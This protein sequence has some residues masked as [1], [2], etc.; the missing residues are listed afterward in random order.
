MPGCSDQS[1]RDAIQRSYRFFNCTV[2]PEPSG[3]MLGGFNFSHRT[4][5][6][7]YMEQ[8][9]GARRRARDIPEVALWTTSSELASMDELQAD[10]DEG[11]RRF[12]E[13]VGRAP[14]GAST[15]LAR[16]L[17][18]LASDVYHYQADHGTMIWPAENGATDELFDDEMYALRRNGYYVVTYVGHPIDNTFYTDK[19]VDWIRRDSP[20][21]DGCP[22]LHSANYEDTGVD[23]PAFH[24]RF[25]G[26]DYPGFDLT[27]PFL[28]GGLTMV[29]TP[30][31]G[32]GI[33]A[34]NWS[35]ITH[36]GVVGLGTDPNSGALERSWER[37]AAT[38]FH[39]ADRDG[40]EI[41]GAI[42]MYYESPDE[43]TYL[44][45]YEFEDNEITVEITVT[46]E[47]DVPQHFDALWENIPVP[48]CDSDCENNRK[49]RLIGFADDG[50]AAL[51]EGDHL[52]DAVH[53]VDEEGHGL[54]VELIDGE[55]SVGVRPVGMTQV[56]YGTRLHIGRLEIPF[57][58]AALAPGES[59]TLRYRIRTLD[60]IDEPP[61]SPEADDIP[62]IIC[63]AGADGDADADAD[64]DGD[65]DG[66]GDG[67]SD[68]DADGDGDADGD[69]DAD[70]DGDGDADGGV[71]P[72][73]EG[74]CDCRAGARRSSGFLLKLI[75]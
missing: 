29:W 57:D 60:P 24:T 62:E 61:P 74:G 64:G 32:A 5:W 72:S 51:S 30:D 3:G 22:L 47:T 59:T 55:R 28:G 1:V 10:V 46:N 16:F 70:G 2:G 75:G 56:Q 11:I 9:G 53:I 41:A 45:Q 37:I 68:V 73:D 42:P 35:P 21:T 34:T 26:D 39:H 6:G 65:S 36:H 38:D 8:Y 20:P 54:A 15:V 33:L 48:L 44:R 23:M 49:G 18:F 27:H 19:W 13:R 14:D 63:S 52:L 31:F 71:T 40:A 50:G 69:V 12:E 58:S 67:D 7:F 43:L 17:T 66:D 4:N 25:C